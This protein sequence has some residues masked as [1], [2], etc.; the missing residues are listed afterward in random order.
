MYKILLIEDDRDI[1]ELIY[2]YFT[3]KKK[4]AFQVDIA[5][6]GQ[7]GLEKAYE[8]NYDLLLLDIMLPN[9]DGFEIC[10]EIRR[11]SDVPIIFITAKA[12]EADQLNGYALG[13]DDYV[14]KPLRLAVL[15]E[16]VNALIKRSKGLVRSSVLSARTLSLNPNNGKVISDGKA[17]SLTPT[18]YIILKVLLENKGR[19]IS[20]DK[21]IVI[22]WGYDSDVDRRVL[23]VHIRNLRKALNQNG[24]LIKTVV[25]RGYKIEDE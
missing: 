1:Q 12:T 21:L 22:V 18:E 20:R 25:R 8:N 17:V 5:T 23:D 13:C 2:E 3:N 14:V 19:I 6:D 11:E 16:K 7:T 24:S 10:S 15:Y 4:D 9:T